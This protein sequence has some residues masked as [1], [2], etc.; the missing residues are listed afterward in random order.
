MAPSIPSLCE[1]LKSQP[2]FHPCPDMVSRLGNTSIQLQP[3]SRTLCQIYPA[4]RCSDLRFPCWSICCCTP[5]LPWRQPCSP[6][7]W[8]YSSCERHL[9]R[10]LGT[11]CWQQVAQTGQGLQA[12]QCEGKKPYWKANCIP[13][14]FL[15]FTYDWNLLH[16][17][18]HTVL[19]YICINVT[20][21][22]N[23]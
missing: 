16:G 1:F 22:F 7:C 10:H 12:L 17:V 11:Y 9:Q 8:I 19:N 18:L 23:H 13:C 3:G 20:R 21:L 4:W 5:S 15:H 14:F 6:R 2:W